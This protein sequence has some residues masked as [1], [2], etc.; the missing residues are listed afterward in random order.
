MPHVWRAQPHEAEAVGELLA[1]FRTHNGSEWPSDNA[2]IA[3]V[4]RLITTP[5]CEYLLA[6]REAGAAAEG[7]VQMRFRWSVWMA[8]EDALL[9]DLFVLA[10]A[11]GHGLGRALVDA[12]YERA[13]RRGCRRI[14]LDVERENETALKLYE[15]A[16]FEIGRHFFARRRVWENLPPEAP[17][18][19]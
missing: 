10:D 19:R 16:G 5:D 15:S 7:V 9:E 18:R 13:R 17:F 1:A 6:A 14:E 11:R 12:V 3:S 4:E 8:A 2:M